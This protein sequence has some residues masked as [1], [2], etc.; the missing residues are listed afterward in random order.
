M[1]F[2]RKQIGEEPTERSERFVV[3]ETAARI[4][5]ITC[6]DD[7]GIANRLAGHASNRLTGHAADGFARITSDTTRVF[8]RK[9]IGEKSAERTERLVAK[10]TASG[11]AG[12]ACN[13]TR[14]A[15]RLTGDAS[16]WFAG[17]ASHRLAWITAIPHYGKA[18]KNA[19]FG[20][21]CSRKHND[22]GQR[23]Q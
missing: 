3:A 16:N 12:I 9:Q 21:R 1:M 8:R 10:M 14:I 15:N 2:R 17:H 22:C 20:S 7:T 5:R 19:G 23:G 11:T 18:S 13:G 4:T 6:N